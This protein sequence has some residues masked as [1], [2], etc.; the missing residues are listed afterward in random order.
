MLSSPLCRK[1]SS[2]KHCTL[3]MQILRLSPWHHPGEWVG[4]GSELVEAWRISSCPTPTP[5]PHPHLLPPSFL[6]KRILFCNPRAILLPPP[7]SSKPEITLFQP[8]RV[9]P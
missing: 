7:R 6:M 9:G 2:R 5:C 8:L 3:S 4:E 1:N